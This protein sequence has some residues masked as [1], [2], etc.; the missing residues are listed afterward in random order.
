MDY[1][2]IVI[3]GG[4]AG[5]TSAIY[6]A[7]AGLKTL[8]AE[9]G[10]VGGQIALTENI[11]NYPGFESIDGAELANKMLA[12]AKTQGVEHKLL[13]VKNITGDKE[14][15]VET[16]E[17]N[18]TTKAVIIAVGSNPRKLGVTGEADYE[19][20]GVH[21]CALCDGVMYKDKVVAVI[22]GGD[23]AI[24]EALYLSNLAKKVIV[25]HRRNEL[26]AEK[27]HQEDAFSKKNIEFIWDSVVT[28]FIGEQFLSKLKIKNV[29]TEKE[30]EIEVNGSFT[31][32]GHIPAT[33]WINVDKNERGYIKVN[34]ELETSV[35]GIFAAGDCNEGDLAQIA[36]AVGDGAIAGTSATKYIESLK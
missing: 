17:G 16:D 5:I 2:V 24:K 21:Y 4:P 22:G 26:R 33:S 31:Y 1:D 34:H 9:K 14:K 3:G 19:G 32:V 35:P 12:Q 8:L 23:A 7:R 27:D 11:E 20:K 15:V 36:T 28:E 6:T 10:L 30:N 29:K 13:D 25:I 18:I